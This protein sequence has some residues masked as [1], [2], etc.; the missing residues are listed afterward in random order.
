M[1]LRVI[2]FFREPRSPLSEIAVEA[3]L[4]YCPNPQKGPDRN[5]PDKRS[6]IVFI[7]FSFLLLGTARIVPARCKNRYVTDMNGFSVQKRG[8]VV[9]DPVLMTKISCRNTVC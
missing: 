3:T 9:G 4:S 5:K 1:L 7:S 2:I 8:E 6:W